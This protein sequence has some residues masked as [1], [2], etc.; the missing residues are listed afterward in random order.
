MAEEVLPR[1]ARCDQCANPA[2]LGC[3][4][5]GTPTGG[6]VWLLACSLH[7]A[8]LAAWLDRFGIV[9]DQTERFLT[10]APAAGTVIS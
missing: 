6:P 5:V 9:V 4:I 3:C 2:A 8:E 1:Q 10:T 7:E